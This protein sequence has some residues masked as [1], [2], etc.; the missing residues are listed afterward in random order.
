M[1]NV[2][3]KIVADKRLE[4]SQREIDFPL[5]AFKDA[6]SPSKKS[7]LAALQKDKAG[8]IFECK[9]ASPSKGLIRAHFDLDEIVSAYEKEAACFSVLTDEKYFQGKFEYLDYVTS[10]VSQPVLNKDFF[11]TPYQ[12]YLAR[13]HNADA[14]LLMLSVLSDDEYKNLHSIADALALDVLTEVSNEEETH[15]ALA[16]GAK[17]IGINNRN[18]R[19]LSTDLTTTERLVPIIRR[20]EAFAGVIISESGIYTN[21]DLRRLNHLVDGYLI[22]SSLMAQDDLN[23]AINTLVYGET[24]VCGITSVDQAKLVSNYPAN[25]LGLIFVEA[26]KRHVSLDA[27]KSIVKSINTSGF[28]KKFVGVF[29]NQSAA[30]VADY[31]NSL[32]LSAVQLHGQETNEYIQELKPLLPRN[33]EIWRVLSIDVNDTS[34]LNNAIEK[35]ENV[36]VDK[37]L[38]DSKV[39]NT[40]GGTGK[41]FDWHLLNEIE[42][43]Q[44]YILAGGIGP[45]NVS[46]ARQTGIATL[47]VNSGVESAPGVKV[48]EKLNDLFSQLRV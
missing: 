11:V 44:H 40:Q 36:L 32:A 25:H 29:Q 3:K 30:L 22:G 2:L 43:K 26:S 33:C 17:I 10:R 39:G 38:L 5:N 24:K 7:F 27:A 23:S 6:L 19:D 8:F 14:V 13:H 28:N 42:N 20:H 21:E 47:D 41:A 31:A 15:R 9:K 45:E 37:Y 34:V 35:Q 1:A 12:I 48:A 46:Q 18:L 16:L 4:V